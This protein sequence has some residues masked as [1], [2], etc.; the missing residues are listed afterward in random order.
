MLID[1]IGCI[2]NL[3]YNKENTMV[4]IEETAESKTIN[5][6]EELIKK[7]MAFLNH[8]CVSKL[9]ISSFKEGMS[10]VENSNE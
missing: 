4:V 1:D 6:F 2:F 8:C 9:K 10:L 3:P 5:E 7:H